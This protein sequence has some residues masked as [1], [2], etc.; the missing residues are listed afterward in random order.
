[1]Q[2]SGSIN[3]YYE[4]PRQQSR[5]WILIHGYPLLFF[6]FFAAGHRVIT[7][8]RRFGAPP[9]SQ[10]ATGYDWDTYAADLN[11]LINTLE[12]RSAS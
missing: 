10:P 12:P 9:S 8:N 2:N 11:T 5:R 6:F 4:P 3:L 7:D 1:M